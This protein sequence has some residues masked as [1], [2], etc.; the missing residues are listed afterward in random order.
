MPDLP[1]VGVILTHNEAEHIACCIGSLK[2]FLAH[3]LVLDSCSADKTRDIARES[4]AMVVQRPFT[5]FASQRQ[6]ALDMVNQDWVLFVDADE[7]IPGELAAEIGKFCRSH[8]ETRDCAGANMP[9][10]NHIVDRIPQWGGFSPDRQ[11]RLLRPDCSSYEHSPLVH[12]HPTLEG[13]VYEFQNPIVHFNYQNWQ[14]FHLKQR[15]YSEL[16]SK[17]ADRVVSFPLFA[18]CRRFLRLF[19]YRYIELDGWRDGLLGFKLALLLAWY[20]GFMPLFLALF[21]ETADSQL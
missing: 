11:L 7:R 19:H 1:V 13:N 2:T 14:Q 6:A 3:V 4:G 5:D 9:R 15:R 20:Y 18:L 12:E 10:H 16:A 21:S 8:E 17:D